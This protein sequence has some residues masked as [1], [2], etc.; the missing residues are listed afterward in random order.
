MTSCTVSQQTGNSGIT[1]LPEK[2]P[3]TDFQIA[4]AI[5][6]TGYERR[7]MVLVRK[8]GLAGAGEAFSESKRTSNPVLSK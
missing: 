2:S 4:R 6:L 1:T 8:A 7:G 5:I 3:T